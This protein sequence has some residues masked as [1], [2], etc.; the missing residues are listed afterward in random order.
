MAES[1]NP[2]D[3][4]AVETIDLIDVREDFEWAQVH[5]RGAKHIPLGE[6][7]SRLGEIEFEKPVYIIC[8]AGGRSMQACEYLEARGL[9]AINVEGGTGAW[10]ASN[11][12]VV[13]GDA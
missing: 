11:L 2:V 6:L 8:A 4:P 5:A 9:E 13:E 7:P 3:V 1:V 10:V 12:P